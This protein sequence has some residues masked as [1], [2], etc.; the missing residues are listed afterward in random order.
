MRFFPLVFTIF[1]F[2]LVANMLGMFPYFFTVTSHVIVTAALAVFIILLVTLM[3]T[4]MGSC[5]LR[6]QPSSGSRHRLQAIDQPLFPV[7]ADISDR[8]LRTKSRIAA[9]T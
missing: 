5:S 9:F 7:T 1:S 4:V 8:Q 6:L 2:V 3:P